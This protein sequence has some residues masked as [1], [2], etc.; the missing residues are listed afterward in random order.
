MLLDRI[1]EDLRQATKAR[2]AIHTAVLRWTLAECNNLRIDKGADLDDE[3]VLAVVKRGVKMRREAQVE[4][5]KG[6]RA[7]LVASEGREMELL[8]V[9]LPEQLT[10]EELRRVV[11]E[12]IAATGA[13]SMQDF[14]VVMKQVMGSHGNEVDGKQVQAIV[15]TCLSG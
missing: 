3:D 10:G 5:E 12:A 11:E 6:G 8:S 2:D 13:A 15:K 7:D 1:R 4:Y 14:G 9:Y